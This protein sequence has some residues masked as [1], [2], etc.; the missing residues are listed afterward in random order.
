MALYPEFLIDGITEDSQLP[1]KTYMLDIEN[2]RIYG[3]VDKLP[4]VNQMIKKALLTPRF[5]C[6]AY[7]D[8]Y[9]SEIIK[10]IRTEMVTREYITN[11]MEALVEETL[12]ADGR[13]DKVEDVSC[14]FEHDEVDIKFTARTAF[15]VSSASLTA[16]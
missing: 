4:A 3:W 5:D 14:V 7:D 16:R 2:G 13:V 6:Y 8:Q 10:L 9:G 15:G 1:S 12:M 11:E